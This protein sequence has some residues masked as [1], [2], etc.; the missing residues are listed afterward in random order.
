M[1]WEG[2]LFVES[3]QELLAMLAVAGEEDFYSEGAKYSADRIYVPR[4]TNNPGL[5]YFYS[6]AALEGM[7][8]VLFTAA[9]RRQS[10]VCCIYG[11]AS[12]HASTRC[13]LARRN[14]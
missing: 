7:L 6:V 4:S 10:G 9:E 5:D 11:D 14:S 8:T 13:P 3:F 12:V 2:H 1:P